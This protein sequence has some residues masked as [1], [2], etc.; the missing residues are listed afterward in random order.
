MTQGPSGSAV[1]VREGTAA[2]QLGSD[3]QKNLL[4]SE[5]VL[6]KWKVYGGC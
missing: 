2:V 3:T 5:K 4:S 1:E 6:L